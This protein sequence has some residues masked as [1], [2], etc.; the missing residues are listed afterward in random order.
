MTPSTHA[1]DVGGTICGRHPTH[2]FNPH[3][4]IPPGTQLMTLRLQAHCK[5]LLQWDKGMG[6]NS[7]SIAIKVSG[8]PTHPAQYH[9]LGE[10]SQ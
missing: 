7:N 8:K 1:T 6:G 4:P 10:A 5:G 2:F 3:S 9:P